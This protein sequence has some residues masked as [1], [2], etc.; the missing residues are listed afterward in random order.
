MVPRLIV[1]SIVVLVI[2]WEAHLIRIPWP[3][4]TPTTLELAALGA[5]LPAALDRLAQF[6][7]TVG[8]VAL[9][10]HHARAIILKVPALCSLVLA[11]IYVVGHKARVLRVEIL[12]LRL[13]H[14]RL[15]DLVMRRLGA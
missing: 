6:N 1:L 4:A 5:L 3:V 9:V 8:E 7:I 15:T 10:G 11:W 14:A 12:D 13:M 2:L